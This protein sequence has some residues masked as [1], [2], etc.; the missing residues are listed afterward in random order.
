VTG[1]ADAAAVTAARQL[2]RSGFAASCCYQRFFG[3]P[4]IFAS[5]FALFQASE[6]FQKGQK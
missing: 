6:T 3:V 2:A 5:L 4:L 1:A